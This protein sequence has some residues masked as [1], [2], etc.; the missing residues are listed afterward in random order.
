VSK[1]RP[2]AAAVAYRDSVDGPEFL[3]VRT[4]GGR[5]WTFPKGHVKSGEKPWEAAVREAGEEAGIEGEIDVVPVAEYDYPNTRR[6]RGDSHVPAYLLRVTDQQPPRERFREPT[7]FPPE[8]ARE[9]LAEGG[10]EPRYVEEHARVLESAV[11]ELQRR[12]G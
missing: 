9:Q 2:V 12:R 8:R 3:L 5:K 1:E 4:K 7:W 6:G 10:R 11:A